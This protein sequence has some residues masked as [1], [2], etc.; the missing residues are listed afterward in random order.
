MIVQAVK[1]A[2]TLMNHQVVRRSLFL[3][4]LTS[5]EFILVIVHVAD[6]APAGKLA[7]VYSRREADASF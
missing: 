1:A 6:S 4:S 3:E 7:H 5:H 2:S